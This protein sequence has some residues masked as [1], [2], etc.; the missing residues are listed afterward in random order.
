MW[1]PSTGQAHRTAGPVVHRG[2]E[3]QRASAGRPQRLRDGR[4]L[5]AVARR[6]P[7]PV[8]LLPA[9]RAGLDGCVRD[10][11]RALL[12]RAG[13]GRSRRRGRQ[14][15]LLKQ[16]AGHGGY[17]LFVADGRLQFIYNFFGESEQRVVAPDPDGRQAHPR[18]RLHPHGRRRGHT[19]VGDA[20]LYVD[21]TEV[22]TL[23]GVKAHP[24][25]FGLAGGGVSVG[26]NLGQPVSSAYVAPFEFNGGTIHRVVVDVSGTRTA[27]PNARWRRPSPGTESKAHFGGVGRWALRQITLAKICRFEDGSGATSYDVRDGWTMFRN[28][29]A[30]GGI[31][32]ML[33]GAAPPALAE[34]PSTPADA[35]ARRTR[36]PRVAVDRCRNH[37]DSLGRPRHRQSAVVLRQLGHDLTEHSGPQRPGAGGAECHTRPAVQSAIRCHQRHPGHPTHQQRWGC[38]WPTSP[39]W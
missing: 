2:A 15:V 38:R 3:V 34:P 14:G 39:R 12:L 27:T 29:M 5:A 30:I 9:H 33:V 18:R 36:P 31:L 13:R 32:A 37:G 10:D 1:P 23:A 24:F 35:P 6:R 22:A 19:P 17:V 20:T 28:V 21:G 4:A 8:R 7:Q 11:R 16:G 26:R 25:T